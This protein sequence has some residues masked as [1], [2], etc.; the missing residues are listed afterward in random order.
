MQ[1]VR[2]AKRSYHEA[3]Y[4]GSRCQQLA[5]SLG[6]GSALTLPVLLRLAAAARHPDRWKTCSWLLFPL[7]A[8]RPWD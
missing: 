5:I 3:V 2:S 4:A 1:Q 7:Y 6:V 8:R